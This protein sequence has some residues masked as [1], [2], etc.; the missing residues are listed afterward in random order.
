M[1]VGPLPSQGQSDS[2]D[3]RDLVRASIRGDEDAARRLFVSIAPIFARAGRS[4]LG[5]HHPEVEDFVQEAA[6]RFF[7]GL[8]KFRGDSH[9]RRY[10]YRIG[11]N[12]AVDWIRAQ[13]M[14]KRDGV[15]VELKDE[16]QAVSDPADRLDHRRLMAA[17]TDALPEEQLQAF[18]LRHGMGL[19]IR[20][21][22]EIAGS[23]ENTVRSRLRLAKSS[24]KRTL[25]A[26]PELLA[27][28]E[29]EA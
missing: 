12:V 14:Q 15:E 23:P 8:E 25:Q 2:G 1:T 29:G 16:L 20:E 26:R 7:R 5:A 13:K 4:T 28:W 27:I 18:M 19:S 11:G 9:V 21:V 22:A 3:L 24:I 6:L 17:V 10:A